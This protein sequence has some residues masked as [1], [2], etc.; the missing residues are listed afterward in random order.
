MKVALAASFV[1]YSFGRR[2]GSLG[3]NDQTDRSV[4]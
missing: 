4:L 3:R 1:D 2:E